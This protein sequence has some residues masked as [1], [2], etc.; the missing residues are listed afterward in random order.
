MSSAKKTGRFPY[1][2]IILILLVALLFATNPKEQQFT[3]FLKDRIREQAKGD[4]TP[5]GDLQR[6]LSGPAASLASIGT[7]RT[8]YYVCSTY[9]MDLPG[10]EHLYLGIFNQF[11]KLN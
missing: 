8:D 9:K 3:S 7:V 6:L 4:E 10:G 11:I 5:G 1:G 2:F